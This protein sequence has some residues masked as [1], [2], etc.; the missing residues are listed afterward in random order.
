[1]QQD[2]QEY[3]QPDFLGSSQP[4]DLNALLGSPSDLFS[5]PLSAP[6][7][8]PDNFWD[9]NNMAMSMDMD[10]STANMFPADSMSHHRPSGSFDWNNDV[11]MFQELQPPPLPSATHTKN[12]KQSRKT[13]TLAPKP[14][15]VNQGPPAPID[16]SMGGSITM[17]NSFAMLDHGGVVDPGILSSRPQSAAANTSFNP[18]NTTGSAENAIAETTKAVSASGGGRRGAGMKDSRGGKMP[19]RAFASSPVKSSS[20]SR[21]GLTRS[22]SET[23]G[24]KSAGRGALVTQPSATRMVPNVRNSQGAD[25]GRSLGRSSGRISP[26]KKQNRLSG[27]ASIPESA[28]RPGSRASVKFYIGEDGRA[29]AEATNPLNA[30]ESKFDA[31]RS[32]TTSDLQQWD[33]DLDGSSSDDEP[34]IIPSRNTSFNASF[35]L[36]DPRR[37]VGSIFHPSRRSIS[38]KSTSTLTTSDVP[39]GIGNDAESEAETVMNDGDDDGGDAA[40][41]L[42]RVKENRQQ[43][44]NQFTRMKSQRLFP[45]GGNG[46]HVNSISPTRTDS[47]NTTDGPEVRCVCHRN[48]FTGFLVQW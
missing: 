43:R 8:A 21:P 2:G 45:T 15:A 27:L 4:Q 42:L 26:L 5:Y 44:S 25:A 47:G 9:P 30:L 39:V 38:D 7:T 40:S 11:Q 35:A 36:P 41:E 28:S 16:T 29:H 31:P 13:R 33:D 19:D 32:F 37:P 17:N 12:Q 6:V 46:F 22:Q 23:R 18:L 48:D 10:F 1:M 34:I 20:A 14:P 3:V 24:R